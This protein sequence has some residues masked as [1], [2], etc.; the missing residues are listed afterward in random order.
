MWEGLCYTKDKK[1]MLMKIT[2]E[3]FDAIPLEQLYLGVVHPRLASLS[4][5]SLVQFRKQMLDCLYE[6]KY[7]I[8]DTSLEEADIKLE[9]TV[10]KYDQQVRHFLD[11]PALLW[12]VEKTQQV[13]DC[14]HQRY[15]TEEE[16]DEDTFVPFSFYGVKDDL[17]F[18][19]FKDVFT[20]QAIVWRLYMAA[21]SYDGKYQTPLDHYYACYQRKKG[22]DKP[23]EIEAISSIVSFVQEFVTTSYLE[24]Y[25]QAILPSTKSLHLQILGQLTSDQQGFCCTERAVITQRLAD[26]SLLD[27]IRGEIIVEN[28]ASYLR[29]CEDFSLYYKEDEYDYEQVDNEEKGKLKLT[30]LAPL[31]AYFASHQPNHE[32]DKRFV[33]LK[34]EKK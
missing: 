21:H 5:F 2:K 3:E 19:Q 27:L 13:V 18:V 23:L 29:A 31:K 12:K 10:R 32:Q 4:P 24:E 22:A 16:Y 11:Y 7:I 8:A 33:L 20:P 30:S 34:Y 1:V 14:L 6:I 26:G 28:H 15:L 17:R 9:K 25:P